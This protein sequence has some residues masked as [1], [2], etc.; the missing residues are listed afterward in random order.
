VRPT[1]AFGLGQVQHFFE[2]GDL[3]LAVVAL[4]T[5]G[6]GLNGA[7][8]LDLCQGEVGGKPALL[9]DAIN[10]LLGLARGKFGA[11]GHV[12][13]ACDVGLVAGDQHAVLGGHQVGLDEVGPQFDGLFVAFQRVV[14]QVAAGATVAHHQGLVAGEGG[15]RVVTIAA[16]GGQQRDG[17]QRQQAGLGMEWGHRGFSSDQNRPLCRRPVTAA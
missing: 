15:I 8:G 10:H 7:Q 2:R 6:Q 17:G 5:L 3:V 16:A 1:R 12:G 9:L 11:L 4:V 14:W 13:G